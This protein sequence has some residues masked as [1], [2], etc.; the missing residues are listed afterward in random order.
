MEDR[1]E[2]RHHFRSG[3]MKR[4]FLLINQQQNSEGRMDARVGK[5]ELNPSQ[6]ESPWQREC[7]VQR[8]V[9]EQPLLLTLETLRRD[10]RLDLARPLASV[11][12][13]FLFCSF[14]SRTLSQT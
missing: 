14:F 10:A 2:P 11:Q 4:A 6:R 12:L 7:G 3:L 9:K 1:L 5:T 13:T 8:A